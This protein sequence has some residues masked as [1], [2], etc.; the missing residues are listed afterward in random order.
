MIDCCGLKRDTPFCPICGKELVMSTGL[1]TL[2]QH[3]RAHL[4]LLEPNAD[5]WKNGV[6]GRRCTD[7]DREEHHRKML[8]PVAKWQA[9]VTLLEETIPL[10]RQ[11]QQ[12]GTPLDTPRMTGWDG[13]CNH[14]SKHHEP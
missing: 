4:R 2:L 12:G 14:V 10:L 11:H 9:W 1:E 3:C 5:Q 13:G 7:E 8:R 6:Y